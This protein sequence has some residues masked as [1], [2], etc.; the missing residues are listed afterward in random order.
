MAVKKRD[1]LVNKV[2]PISGSSMSG[3]DYRRALSRMGKNFFQ[4][5]GS[6]GGSINGGSLVANNHVLTRQ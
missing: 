6:V 2:L 1:Y 3:E 4:Q 5:I